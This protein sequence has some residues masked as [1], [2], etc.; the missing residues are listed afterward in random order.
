MPDRDTSTP[1]QARGARLTARQRA[2]ISHYLGSWNATK[3]AIAAGYSA[4]SA[5][6]IGSENLKKPEIQAEIRAQ[7]G[8]RAMPAGEVLERIAAQARGTMEHFMTVENTVRVYTSK[9]TGDSIEEPYQRIFIDLEKARA[10][11]QLHLIKKVKQTGDSTEI[12]LYDAQAALALLGKHHG[13]FVEQTVSDITLK[14][15]PEKPAFV[16]REIVVN[17]ASINP[18]NP[19]DGRTGTAPGTGSSSSAP[20]NPVDTR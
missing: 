15:D 13:L 8:E 6:S 14:G 16:V 1:P 5:Y 11:E 2:F 20:A 19:T 4:K 3:A 10:A 9:T 12:E 18:A 17:H 7:I